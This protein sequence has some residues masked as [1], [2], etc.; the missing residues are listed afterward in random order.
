MHLTVDVFFVF[1]MQT[2]FV[3][4]TAMPVEPRTPG[5]VRV[6]CAHCDG[7]FQVVIFRLFFCYWYSIP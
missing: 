6:A 2:I 4:P 3:D 7:V 1:S 5:N